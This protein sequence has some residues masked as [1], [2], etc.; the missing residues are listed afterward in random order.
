MNVGSSGVGWARIE[1]P[2]RREGGDR[3]GHL[4]ALGMLRVLG[5]R[6]PKLGP[7]SSRF[8]PLL[9]PRDIPAATALPAAHTHARHQATHSFRPCHS[10]LHRPPP[11]LQHNRADPATPQ[12]KAQAQPTADPLPCEAPAPSSPLVSVTAATLSLATD[13]HAARAP[14]ASPPHPEGALLPGGAPA[15]RQ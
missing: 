8:A 3:A 12:D 14:R 11:A 10:R 13:K 15:R 6:V 4:G 7:S 2:V 5:A 9:N 1:C